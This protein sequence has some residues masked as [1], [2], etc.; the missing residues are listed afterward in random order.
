MAGTVKLEKSGGKT[1]PLYEQ[2]RHRIRQRIDSKALMV[3]QRLP[4]ISSL[5]K[6]Y[7]VDYRTI[8][9][10][11]LLL[12]QDG[13]IACEQRKGAVVIQGGSTARKLSLAVVWASPVDYS[14]MKFREGMQEYAEANGIVF[15]NYSS[16][17][18][19]EGALEVLEKIEDY[20]VDG[21]ILLP[22]FTNEYIAAIK[23]LSEKQFPMVLLRGVPDLPANVVCADDG[24][25]IYEATHYLIEKYHRPAYLVIPNLG[26]EDL[27]AR[28]DGYVRAMSDAGY[29]NNIEQ[30]VS[31]IEV[32]DRDPKYWPVDK[33]WMP[34]F[35]AAQR[36]LDR[37][38]PF[39]AS[40]VCS[41]DYTARG[42]YEAA[43]KRKLV[44]GRDVMV[45]SQSDL[46]MAGL[47]D[48][49]LTTVKTG[50]KEIGFE[51]A[52]LLHDIITGK[53][54]QP[55]HIHVPGKLIVRESA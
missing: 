12:E 15:R 49:G 47:M 21:V 19:H 54:T 14:M 4:A 18:G 41:S 50:F 7:Q 5:V 11:L 17:Q 39:P 33:K 25:A 52:K 30:Y 42:V 8:R 36:L 26:L 43:A 24:S 22:F 23:K 53:V 16:P 1:L 28:Y 34:G 40:V 27:Q 9:S 55:V 48:P 10:A 45:A 35:F 38:I 31:W 32:N 46:P 29:D 37:N 13:V 51:A 6:E 20:S 2:I 3:G 44:I